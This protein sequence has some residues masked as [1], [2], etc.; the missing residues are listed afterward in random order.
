MN[1]NDAISRFNQSTRAFP[2]DLL[3]KA[4]WKLSSCPE[5][6]VFLRSNFAVSQGV[7]YAAHWL[8]GIGDRHLQNTLVSTKTGRILGIDFGCAFGYATQ[9]LKIPE[10]V[11]FRL[12]P[13][14]LNLLKPLNETG[15]IKQTMIHCLRSFRKENSVFIAILEVFAL[16]P[17]LDWLEQARTNPRNDGTQITAN[18][19]PKEKIE[20]VKRKLQGENPVTI[21]ED[22][23]CRYHSK[24]K[25]SGKFIEVLKGVPELNVRA[26]L[27]NDKLTEE[28][29]VDCLIDLATDKHVL[30]KTYIGWDPWL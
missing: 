22:D 25:Q 13:Q 28:Q 11:P 29:Q 12:T 10:L 21:F 23:I 7:A 30:A 19:Y 5:H 24:S 8:M 18:W 1:R 27:P 4:F 26:R 2:W 17:S 15:W 9:F 6:F 3:R 20:K 16:E 14:I